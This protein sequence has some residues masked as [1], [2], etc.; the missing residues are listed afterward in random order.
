MMRKSRESH[1]R[2]FFAGS[3]LFT[4]AVAFAAPSFAQAND[5]PPAASDA[6]PDEGSHEI[7]VTGSR[8]DRA[9]FEA[10]TPTTVVGEADLRQGGRTNVAAVL[11]DLPQFRYSSNPAINTGNINTGSEGSDLRGL[12]SARTLLLLNNHRFVGGGDLNSIPFSVVE[13]VEVVTGGASAAWGSGAVAGVVNLILDDDYNGF[14]AVG[15]D[16]A[17]HPRRRRPIY[18]RGQRRHRFRRRA[19]QYPPRRGIL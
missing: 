2:N 10:P 13:R 16:R 14:R 11:G 9:G 8:I 3:A 6:A 5:P 18:A 7:V 15:A 1:K 17:L 4:I 12:G 19:R